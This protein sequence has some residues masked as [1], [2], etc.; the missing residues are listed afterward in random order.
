MEFHI[1]AFVVT[2]VVAR[3]TVSL[4]YLGHNTSRCGD[5]CVVQIVRDEK[6]TRIGE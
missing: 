6:R 4:A 5:L 2:F 3:A 1:L